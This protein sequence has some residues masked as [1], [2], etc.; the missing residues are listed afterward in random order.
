MRLPVKDVD[1][2]RS[3]DARA[4]GGRTCACNTHVDGHVRGFNAHPAASGRDRAACYKGE[5]LEC[6][7]VDGNGAGGTD[8]SRR[9]LIRSLLLVFAALVSWIGFGLFLL[10]V[11]LGR[12]NGHPGNNAE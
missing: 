5:C 10:D 8:R 3:T 6:E 11:R 2:H 9:A 4:R 1:T 12:G 7:H